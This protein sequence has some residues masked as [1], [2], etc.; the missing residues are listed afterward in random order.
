MIDLPDDPSPRGA[1]LRPMDFGA[2]LE[3]PLGGELLRVERLGSRWSINVEMPPMKHDDKGRLFVSRLIRG[4]GEGVRMSVPLLG[5]DPGSPGTPVV[6][7]SGATGRTLPVKG[8]APGY[9][10][11]EG[12]FFS[13]VRGTRHHLYQV[14]ADATV[15]G[16]GTASLSIWPSLRTQHLDSDALHVVD[17]KIEGLVTA[18]QLSWEM[19]LGNFSGISFE[20]REVA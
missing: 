7:G 19:A 17:P 16:G 1:S 8:A 3:S 18:D 20:L 10:F 11:K 6:N 5:F 13:L 15:A 9:I 4:I 2:T 12:Q 14:S